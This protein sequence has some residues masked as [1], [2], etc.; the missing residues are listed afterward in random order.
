VEEHGPRGEPRRTPAPRW[1]GSPSRSADTGAHGRPWYIRR[2]VPLLVFCAG[3]LLSMVLAGTDLPRT[4]L[5]VLVDG[6][7]AT[8]LLAGMAGLA[9]AARARETALATA[10]DRVRDFLDTASDLIEITT[11]DG[12]VL[13]VNQAWRRTFG[14][15]ETEP[16]TESSEQAIAPVYGG[17]YQA[18]RARLVAGE[19]VGEF[20]GVFIT[21]RGRRVVLAVRATCRFESGRP[22]AI[23]RMLRDVTAQRA[24]EEAQHR[25]VATLEAT[26]DFVGVG[27]VRGRGVY[28]NRA[29]RRMIGVG[30]N[31]DIT[32]FWLRA[33]FPLDAQRQMIDVAI[34]SA[35]RDGVWQGETTLRTRDGRQIPV[36]QVVVAHESSQG[37]VWFVSTIMRDISQWKRIDRMKNEFVSTV[38]HELR[39]PLTSIRGALGLLEAGAAGGLGPQALDLVRIGRTNTERLIR[40]IGDMLDLDKIEAGQL[41]LRRTTL[42]PTE[43]VHTAIDGIRALADQYQVRLEE[44]VAAHRTFQGDRDRVI[45]V[46]TNLLSNAVK[47]SPPGSVISVRAVPTSPPTETPTN[48]TAG[49][50]SGRAPVRFEVSNPGPGIA[51]GDLS[52]LFRR[53]QQLDSSDGRKR[54]GT[55]LGLA[56]S[57]AIVEQHG[58][59]IGVESEPGVT[60][61]FWFEL[62]AAVGPARPTPL[63]GTPVPVGAA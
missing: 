60:T 36:S 11:P 39:T 27:D 22:A 37:G 30:E 55:G 23:L 62:P 13:L 34:P 7:V 25:L 56:I 42:M 9:Q 21:R 15:G 3:T 20:E 10:E 4:P 44:E 14:F 29:G 48:E 53:F 43:V 33:I 46:L 58:G 47:F 45:Q 51:P 12:A 54:G 50:S 41:D 18:L 2:R 32:E 63:Q 24:A 26:T 59:R 8:L 38:S 6:L 5:G 52:R 28:I 40:L 57:K 16:V 61:T 49:T 19:S 35:I 17:A 31:D 1:A